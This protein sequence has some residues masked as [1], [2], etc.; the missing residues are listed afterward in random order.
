MIYAIFKW[1]FK[2]SLFFFYKKISIIGEENIPVKGPLIIVSNHPNTLMDPILISSIFNRR[3]GFIAKASIFINKLVSAIFRFFHI[4]PIIRKIDVKKGEKISNED[5]FAKCHEY[6]N[7]GKTFLIFPEGTS[8]Y[9]LKLREIKT[10]TARIALSFEDLNGFKGGLKILPIALDYS[11]AVDFRSSIAVIIN[12]PIIVENYKKQYALDMIKTVRELNEKIRKDIAKYIPHANSKKEEYFLIKIHK[13]Y[14]EYMVTSESTVKSLRLRNMVSKVMHD[15]YNENRNHYYEIQHDVLHYFE[16]I[17]EEKL[18]LG[19]FR[20]S[21][22]QKS[23]YLMILWYLLKLIVL[24]PIY[25]FGL[26]INYIPYIAPYKIFKS[27]KLEIEYKS[28]VQMISGLILFP[29]FYWMEIVLFQRFI[30]GQLWLTLLLPFI[31]LIFGYISLFY[32][33]ELKRIFNIIHFYFYVKE[34]KKKEIM[35]LRDKISNDIKKIEVSYSDT[36]Q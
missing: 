3:I 26:V 34:D 10:G 8:Y 28:S 32:W 15:I 31:F 27:L 19:F 36:S 1:L 17:K 18:T 29:L 35:I 33:A 9:E 2:I 14:I 7:E 6:L 21:F 11:D 25:I 12:E 30:S 24:F 5:T 22:F 4:I 16:L 23:K 20:D 13:F